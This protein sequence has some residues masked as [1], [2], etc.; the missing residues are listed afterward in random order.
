M[1][2]R[3]VTLRK[4]ESLACRRPI[5]VYF[6][7]TFGISWAGALVVAV[8]TIAREHQISNLT[9]VLMFPAMLLGPPI[10]GIILTY[11]VDGKAG[12][13][14]LLQRICR[15]RFAASWHAALL[16]P[17]V[18]VL[19][20]LLLLKK[21]VS[22]AFTPNHFYLGILFGVPAGIFEEIGWMGFVFP[23]LKARLNSLSAAIILGILWGLWHLPVIDYLGAATPHGHYWLHFLVAFTLV[24]TAMRVLIAWLYVNTGSVLLAQLMHVSSTGALVIF[25]PRVSPGQEAMWYSLYGCLLWVFVTIVLTIYGRQLRFAPQKLGC[26]TPRLKTP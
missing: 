13:T 18:L 20:V 2:D 11:A 26:Q 4:R 21:V 12:L 15:L 14:N 8:V 6:L 1:S 25:S 5:L 16:I 22:P 10:S 3:V 7:L 24:L 17:P 9:G 19:A 23:K